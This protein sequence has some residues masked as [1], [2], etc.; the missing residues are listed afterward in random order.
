MRRSDAALGVLVAVLWGL[1]FVAI[2]AGLDQLPPLFFVS[3]RYLLA[4]L[5]LI[6]FVPRPDVGW[7]TVVAIEVRRALMAVSS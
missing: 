6:L 7:R 5:P 3:L 1:N 4:V 2:D